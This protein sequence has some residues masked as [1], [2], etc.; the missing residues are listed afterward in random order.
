[1]LA[2]AGY[3]PVERTRRRSRWLP[4]QNGRNTAATGSRTSLFS[5]AG[6]MGVYAA[7]LS[8]RILP[9]FSLLFYCSALLADDSRGNV[10]PCR[11]GVIAAWVDREFNV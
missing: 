5:A 11:T 10:P 9:A 4:R 3:L 6:R 1:M 7:W 8:I 2:P